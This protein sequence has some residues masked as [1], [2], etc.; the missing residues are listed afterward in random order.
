MADARQRLFVALE[1]PAAARQAV[2]AV[3]RDWKRLEVFEGRY[4]RPEHLHLTLKF[5]GEVPAA[6]VAVYAEALRAVRMRPLN[7]QLDEL[8]VFKA[9]GP[10][11]ILWLHVG[12]E[13]VAALQQD[14]DAALCP[15]LQPEQRFMGHVT[16]ARIKRA[17]RRPFM[18]ALEGYR[19]QPIPFVAVDFVLKRS[20]LGPEGPHYEDV[21]RY[22][23]WDD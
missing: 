5:I 6:D 8:G 3:Q 19:L 12:G 10:L 11:R 17:R 15:P 14:V 23:A 2:A 9:T 18:A 16:I 4:T 13:G 20:Q 22:P 21:E 7:L 1:L